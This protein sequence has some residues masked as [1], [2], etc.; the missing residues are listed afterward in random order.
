MDDSPRSL[1]RSRLVLALYGIVA[2]LVLPVY[3]HFP[4]P[5][6][7]SRWAATVAI[8]DQGTLHIEHLIPLISDRIEDFSERD[9]HVYANKAPGGS[10]VAVPAYAAAR[11]IT[12][13][14]NPR[15]LRGTLTAMRWLTST[16]PVLLLAWAMGRQARRA[17][18][19]DER[20]AFGVAVLLFATPLFAYGLLLFAHALAAACLFG[21]W[22]LLFEDG[23]GPRGMRDAGAGCLLGLAAVC[24]YPMAIPG[25]VLLACALWRLGARAAVGMALGALP[26]LVALAAYNHV[27]FGSMFALSSSFERAAVFRQV[28]RSG[29]WGVGLPSPWLALRLLLDPSKGLFVFSPVLV[30]ALAAIPAARRRLDAPAFWS[31]VAV[32]ASV[33][34]V[35]AGFSDWHGG[36]TVGARYMVPALP[37]LVHLLLLGPP[38]FVDAPLLGASAA[39]VTL[40]AL[41]FPFVSEAYALPWASFATPLLAEGLVAPNLLHLVWRPLAIAVPFLLVGA[42]LFLWS[43]P[44]RFVLTLAGALAWAL[45]AFLCV[46]IFWPG[47]DARR[48]YV[49]MVYFER[50]DKQGPA[51]PPVDP[52]IEERMRKDLALPPSGWPF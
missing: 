15:N 1:R 11:V 31:L 13:S 46:A 40:T 28:R 10:F 29:L 25:L 19:P 51:A 50:H 4:S 5:N 7:L 37:F 20:V 8:V 44:R 52:R 22:L 41:V 38:R 17:G 14:P 16:V 35:Y 32:P 33:L 12:G 39:A 9:G 2:V 45:L 26:W 48:W 24:D 18:V 49:E 34:L 42:A 43:R 6:E 30:L 23:R 21:A 36:W 47:G 3:P 27:A